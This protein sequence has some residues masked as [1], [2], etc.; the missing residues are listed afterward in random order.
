MVRKIPSDV[1]D[2]RSLR[3]DGMYYE[4]KE[5]LGQYPCGISRGE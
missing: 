4:E 1:S 2:F 3:E 5:P